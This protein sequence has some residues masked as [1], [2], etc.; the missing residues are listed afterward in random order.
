M[1]E[2]SDD[3][4]RTEEPSQRKLQH[5]RSEGQVAQSREVSTWFMLTTGG[6]IVLLLAPSIALSLKRSL[7]LFVEPQRFLTPGGILWP[8]VGRALG[9]AATSLA[10]PLLFAV[11]AAVA[12]TVVQTGLV[13]ATEKIGFDLAH[14][15][16]AAGMRRLFSLRA[17]F[18]F[19]KSLAKVA[20]VVAV[21]AISL[22]G[23]LDRLPLLSGAPAESILGEIDH[24]VLRLLVGVLAALTALA[25]ADYF[26]QRFT[27]MRSLRMTKQEVKEEL[28]QSE[29]DPIIKARLKQIRMERARRRMMAAV[30]GA[31]VVITNPTHYAVALKYEMGEAGAPRVV[32]KGADLI[33]QRIREL[34]LENDVPIVE[35]P[36]LARALYA[37]VELDREIPPE[38]YKAVAEIIGYVFR[39]KGKLKP[40]PAPAAALQ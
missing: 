18:E 21:A 3:S 37:G 2:D 1:A 32:A 10:L 29:G 36:P 9:E 26:Y 33:A 40:V 17:L 22:S 34:A 12:G 25:A 14:L 30:P 31:S 11:L 16:P 19:L 15:S 13:F 5:A 4:Q 7:G 35:N 20:V 28:K 6:A 38:H 8:A 39:L 27:L 24:A 23:E